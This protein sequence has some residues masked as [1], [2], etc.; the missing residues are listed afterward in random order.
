MSFELPPFK[1]R[2]EPLRATEWNAVV[3]HV[4]RSQRITGGNGILVTKSSTGT[5]IVLKGVQEYVVSAVITRI[6]SPN[7][8]NG[9][10]DLSQVTYDVRAKG[11]PEFAEFTAMTPRYGRPDL[12]VEGQPAQVG[13]E[14]D[15]RFRQRGPDQEVFLHVFT[16]KT[17]HFECEP[18]AQAAT[19]TALVAE[20]AA[21]RAELAAI[22]GGA[23]NA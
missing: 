4:H 14:V 18:P 2:G 10:Q 19:V 5:R 21:M 22:K 9:P 3:R 15:L 20:V 23:G 7:G 17:I 12:G 6:N 13:D 1:R 8:D 11:R 16:E